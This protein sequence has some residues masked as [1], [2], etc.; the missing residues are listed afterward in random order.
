M[1]WRLHGIG[2]SNEKWIIRIGPQW[3]QL[4][5]SQGENGSIWKYLLLKPS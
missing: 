4:W 5:E 1:D 3:S 2:N